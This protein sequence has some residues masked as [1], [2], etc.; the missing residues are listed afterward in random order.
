LAATSALDS[1]SEA[2]V[3]AALDQLVASKK[4]TTLIVAHRLSTIRNADVIVVISKGRV[5]EKGTHDQLIAIPDGQYR[6]L[7]QLQSIPGVGSPPRTT[8]RRRDSNSGPGQ[9]ISTTASGTTAIDVKE[10]GAK[11]GVDKARWV[12]A[13]GLT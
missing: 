7:V 11:G 10:E 5:V 13:R 2:I 9:I 6:S 4:R 12:R 3:Q 1:E 8:E